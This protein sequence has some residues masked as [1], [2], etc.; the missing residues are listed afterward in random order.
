VAAVTTFGTW[1]GRRGN[2]VSDYFL[3][4]R[5]IPWWAIT[6][7]I[8][9][10]ET[11]TLT[12]IGVPGTAYTGDWRFLQLVFGYVVGRL[13]ISALLVP[14]YFR[15]QLYTSYE[16]L[17]QRLGGRVRALSS[18]IFLVS[19]TLADGIRLH[20][21][22]LVLAVATTG[23]T[24]WEWAFI[25]LLGAAMIVYTEQGGVRAT[26]W[27]DVVQLF[28]YL[29]GALVCLFAV[30]RLLPGGLGGALSA[31]Q[32]AGKTRLLD[33][34]FDAGEPYTFWAGLIGGAFLT[35]ATHGTDHYLVQR[36]L[37]ARGRKEAQLGLALTGPVVLVQFVLFLT[38]GTLL[39]TY[40][41]GRAFARGDEVLPT[42]VATQLP[43]AA[44]GFIL[45]AIVAAALSPSLNSMASATLRD[46]Y[47]PYLRPQ[48]G[49]AEQVRMGKL[50]TV[51]WGVA[52]IGVALLAQGTRKALDAGLAVLGYASG[53]T[54]GAFLLAVL[55]RR[56]TA[57]ATLAGMACGLTA[58]LVALRAFQVA[59]TW[60]VAV[61]ALV[62]FAVG[63]TVSALRTAGP[64]PRA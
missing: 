53:P 33:F 19:R 45:A 8:V 7:C 57:A 30:I 6:A 60:N 3:G 17:Q 59:W 23:G 20:A 2:S 22:A 36:L 35:L 39:W 29:A 47:L 5:R 15:G 26:V 42:F 44:A 54:V 16:L 40:Y 27:T 62:T 63:W 25:L 48:A 31:A 9:A 21:A 58:S 56:A 10:T 12:F 4:G 38:L 61:G 13:L 32:A 49:D 41:G 64:P 52:Q 51:G 34:S 18:G 55:V 46:F 11:S 24:R 37:V 43:P 1:L 14:A 28:V 50:F